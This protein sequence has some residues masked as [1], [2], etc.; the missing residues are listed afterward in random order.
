MQLGMA[1][2]VWVEAHTAELRNSSVSFLIAFVR[3]IYYS[4][5]PWR[6]RICDA[7]ICGI[8]GFYVLEML[9]A[10]NLSDTWAGVLCV[11]L[12][13]L[14]FGKITD[15]VENIAGKKLK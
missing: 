14:G 3:G 6:Q 7:L 2:A 15:F 1:L 4:N 11:L 10:A 9:Y 12:G 13:C 8:M 5:R